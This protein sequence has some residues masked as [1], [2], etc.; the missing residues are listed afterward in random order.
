M[1]TP[2]LQR[3]IR[4]PN[5]GNRWYVNTFYVSISTQTYMFTFPNTQYVNRIAV[6]QMKK[7]EEEE[8]LSQSIIVQQ[9]H[10]DYRNMNCQYFM[11]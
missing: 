1:F 9:S 3:T 8:D 5:N 4:I 10:I 7:K 2:L 6:I 11:K